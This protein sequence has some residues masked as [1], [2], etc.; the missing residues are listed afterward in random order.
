MPV[1]FARKDQYLC[2]LTAES[3]DEGIFFRDEGSI[4]RFVSL[5]I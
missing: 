2:S 4:W 5:M 1:I 3:K